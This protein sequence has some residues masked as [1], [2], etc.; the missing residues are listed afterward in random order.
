[1]SDKAIDAAVGMTMMVVLS[2]FGASMTI[3]RHNPQ[4]PACL[5]RG[6]RLSTSGASLGGGL[7]AVASAATPQEPMMSTHVDTVR[8][9]LSI[10]ASGRITRHGDP[11][12]WMMVRLGPGRFR[13]VIAGAVTD[14]R[15]SC[16][17]Y[18]E[19][20]RLSE[21]IAAEEIDRAEGGAA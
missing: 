20:Y 4:T 12:P 13:A 6:R 9:Q 2:L 3:T 1:M 14:D 19:L 8:A 21:R 11:T 10:A 16:S 7:S 17:R 5:E 15:C 18:S